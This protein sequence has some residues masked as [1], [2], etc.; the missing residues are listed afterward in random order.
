ML[1]NN[2]KRFNNLGFYIEY[3]LINP[4]L[5]YES[6][7][8][9]SFIIR[10]IDRTTGNISNIFE[11]KNILDN[12]IKNLLY[13]YV[14]ILSIPNKP[15]LDKI[16]YISFGADFL[17]NLSTHN[18]IDIEYTYDIITYR[19]AYIDLQII[20]F[21][22]NNDYTQYYSY[23]IINNKVYLY[24]QSTRSI[25]N[26]PYIYLNINFPDNTTFN[27]SKLINNFN[28]KLVPILSTTNYIYYKAIKQYI[29]KTIST[30]QSIN[31]LTISLSDSTNKKL[32][33]N[34]L[35][36]NL[37]QSKYIICNCNNDIK[38]ASCYCTY[39]RHPFN[40]KFQIDIG[41]KIGQIQNELINKVF[42]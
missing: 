27:T 33:N 19:V 34:F 3:S 39:I 1:K 25:L 10:N 18:N 2:K 8:E 13:I 9:S 22:I 36:T 24:T 17:A 4:A 16:Q 7:N 38:L 35:N 40:P 29:L 14:H 12:K 28:F 11:W 31:N 21:I 32:T 23:E 5:S 26:E 37:Y 42:Y 15:F 6:I 41:F 20:D 30:I